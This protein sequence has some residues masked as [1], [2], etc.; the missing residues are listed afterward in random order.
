MNGSTPVFIDNY[1]KAHKFGFNPCT[2]IS[3]E[4]YNNKPVVRKNNITDSLGQLEDLFFSS[5][6]RCVVD[7][8][9][10]PY[11]VIAGKKG[12]NFDDGTRYCQDG[13]LKIKTAGENDSYYIDES[14]I[15]LTDEKGSALR[16]PVCGNN[17]L[18]YGSLIEI[19]STDHTAEDTAKLIANAVNFATLDIESL[20]YPSERKAEIEEHLYNEIIG[21][22]ETFNPKQQQNEI[23]I[24]SAYEGKL[25]VVFDTKAVFEKV[26]S[27]VDTKAMK[28]KYPA[29]KKSVINL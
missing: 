15:F 29:F 14:D 19:N 8:H 16:C 6:S 11:T 22:S 9:S 21:V 20:R 13:Y 26:M 2:F 12:C 1:P 25:D 28:M 5:V 24:M 27:S 17:N 23:R 4:L 3:S 18:G 7:K 10:L